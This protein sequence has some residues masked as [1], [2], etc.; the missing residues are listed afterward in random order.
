[1]LRKEVFFLFFFLFLLFFEI[2]KGSCILETL[3]DHMHPQGTT[4]IQKSLQV[5]NAEVRL[6]KY[7]L[8]KNIVEKSPK[9]S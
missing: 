3:E 6:F 7:R 1:M 4:H 2:H 5:P 8:Y 9:N